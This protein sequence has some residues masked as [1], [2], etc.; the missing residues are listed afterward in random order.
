MFK[1]PV[2]FRE[3]RTTEHGCFERDAI[4]VIIL[5]DGP[6]KFHCLRANHIARQCPKTLI[7]LSPVKLVDRL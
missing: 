1:F 5:R 3:A 4:L 2:V 6:L 7:Q